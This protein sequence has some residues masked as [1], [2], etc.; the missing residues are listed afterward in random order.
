MDYRNRRS[1]RI[2]HGGR[3]LP[4]QDIRVM[5]PSRGLNMLSPDIFIDNKDSWDLMN[6][7]FS[8]SGAVEKRPGFTS[9]GT[10]LT[11][12]PTGMGVYR[13]NEA[14]KLA[15]IDGGKLKLYDDSN[16]TWSAV[17]G[18]ITHSSTSSSFLTSIDNKLYVWD[19]EQGG[20]V[21]DGTTE[22][23]P[24]RMPKG[25]FS[26]DY[27]DFHIVSGVEGQPFRVY[28]S[29]V[30][31]T[32]RFTRKD[33]PSDD[34]YIELNNAAGVPG[35]TIFDGDKSP[36]AIDVNRYDGEPVTGFGF[37]QDALIIF[38]EHSIYSMEFNDKRLPVL[39]RITNA[40][41]C[42]AHG[43]ICTVE[44]DCYFFYNGAIYVLGNE[45]NYYA[46]IRTNELSSRIRPLLEQIN[47]N[48]FDRIRSYF[49]DNRYMLS[50]PRNSNYNNLLIV[51][52]KRYYAWTIWD[53]INASGINSY[54]D[55]NGKM[56]LVF[57]ES[58]KP[59]MNRFTWGVYNDNGEPISAH[60]QSRAFHGKKV[61]VIKYWKE[62]RFIFK[63]MSGSV[64]VQFYDENGSFGGNF[65]L[66]M[67]QIGGVGIDN[68][69]S[70]MF[71][72]SDTNSYT[73]VDLGTSTEGYSSITVE[74][75][76][77]FRAYIK[78]MSR[79]FS[80]RISNDELNENFSLLAFN[81]LFQNQ[82]PDLF[83][84]RHTYL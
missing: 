70:I 77:A 3:D 13:R 20:T 28:I 39:S 12:A 11:N 10:G 56:Q 55:E 82:D 53:N 61:D 15:V 25:K 58:T 2:P 60:W 42:S 1:L 8:S 76:M 30:R 78:K 64:D 38:K 6:I 62:I 52:D 7:D 21:Y 22:T 46:T 63:K 37:H 72:T 9:I 51:Y 49:Y 84:S 31:E 67:A 69:G 35:A 68:F 59:R 26:I 4:F 19:G 73:G 80:F 44:N 71:G 5:N 36:N 29:G 74:S 18:N 65:S 32:S 57:V 50:I 81:V 23:R 17:G 34:E 47:P 16:D 83:E 41:G 66:D 43:S 14:S 40:Y 33:G 75:T 48:S 79:T 45:P 27:K 24:G 54:K